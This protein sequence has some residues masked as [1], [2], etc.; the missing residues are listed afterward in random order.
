MNTI[1]KIQNLDR[2]YIFIVIA[3]SVIIPLLFP[4]GLPVRVSA[5]VQ[6][7]FDKIESLPKGSIVL[8]SF[9]YGPSSAPELQPM[10]LATLRHCFKNDLRV[11]VMELWVTGPPLANQALQIATKEYNKI[12][13]IDY[14]H[15]GY[16]S[17]AS[18][19]LV[20]LGTDIHSAYPQDSRGTDIAKLPLMKEVKNYNDII[21]VLSLS[22]G[23]PGTR[24]WIQQVHSR[25][26]AADGGPV[27]IISGCTAVSAPEF[28]PYI[29]SGQLIGLLGGLKGAAEYEALI[30]QKGTATAGMDAQSIA[31]LLIVLFIILGNIAYFISKK[32]PK[33]K[34]DA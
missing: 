12:E 18:V 6:N 17:G 29:N 14:V 33:T 20:Q 32:T 19:L 11:V 9:D 8:A 34:V 3:L 24:E 1:E 26:R 23:T 21:C 13:G 5:P 28:Y 7:S 25:F 30:K 31:H 27:P 16:K 2:R 15:L 10:A 22:A 4:F